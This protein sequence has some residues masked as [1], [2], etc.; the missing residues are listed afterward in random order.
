M[1]FLKHVTF[2]ISTEG[3]IERGCSELPSA[4]RLPLI[5]V[6]LAPDASSQAVSRLLRRLADELEGQ[7]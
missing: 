1:I 6:T 5:S 3:V 4:V 2:S 7:L